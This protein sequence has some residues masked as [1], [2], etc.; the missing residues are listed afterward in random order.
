MSE[1]T[2]SLPLWGRVGVR[3]SSLAPSP[4]IHHRALTP[5]LS[6][7]EGVKDKFPRS[8]GQRVGVRGSA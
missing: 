4:S 2:G 7:R 3:A 6:Q 5:A 8:S 1:M